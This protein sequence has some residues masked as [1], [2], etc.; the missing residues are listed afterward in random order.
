MVNDH[1]TDLVTGFAGVVTEK[2]QRAGKPTLLL[3]A[4]D[5]VVLGRKP[6]HPRLIPEP[7]VRVDHA[8]RR[9]KDAPVA[10]APARYT[11]PA[12]EAMAAVLWQFAAD[13]LLRPAAGTAIAN[14]VGLAVSREHV[15]RALDG[16]TKA[17]G[18]IPAATS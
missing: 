2:R 16:L 7:Q 3:V 10:G 13:L 12:Q 4:Q 15:E 17:L 18:Y 11:H 8:I 9:A 1:V 14:D 5:R 6:E